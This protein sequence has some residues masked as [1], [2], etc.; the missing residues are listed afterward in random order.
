MI[1]YLIRHGQDNESVRGGWS[2]HSLSKLGVIQAKD[3]AEDMSDY[4]IAAIYSSDLR[5]TMQTAQILADKLQLPITLMPQFREVNN[6]DLSGMDNEMALY[7]YPGLF[8]NQLG[9]EECYPNGESPKDFY[10]RVSSAWEDF[11]KEIVKQNKN[12]ALVTH[13][14]VIHVIRAILE[15]RPYSNSGNNRKVH[16][17]E[18]IPLIYEDGYWV[19]GERHGT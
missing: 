7:R 8:W 9:W 15:N 13:G 2:D 11:S 16:Y 12:V 6:G 3:L 1:C 19:E 14:G 18:V 17:T 5:R 4:S 10:G